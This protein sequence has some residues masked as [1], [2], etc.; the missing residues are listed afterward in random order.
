M[1][2]D[3]LSISLDQLCRFAIVFLRTA[4]MLSVTPIFNSRSI[5]VTTRMAFALILSFFLSGIVDAPSLLGLSAG[6]IVMIGIREMF[7]GA[8]FGFSIHLLFV[9]VQI[10]GQVTGMMMGF[11][12]VNVFD[13]QSQAQTSLIS[14]FK[15]ILALLFFLALNGHHYVIEGL[16]Q[17]F[18]LLPV[19]TAS[20][21]AAAAE[22]LMQRSSEVFVIAMKIAAPGM[23]SLLVL[24][25]SLGLIAKTVPQMNIFIVGFPLKIGLGM[26]SL[27]FSLPFIVILFRGMWIS[28]QIDSSALLRAMGV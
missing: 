15:Y 24:D 8:L 21:T 18:S 19:G 27:G 20:M 13:P 4:I 28:V 7:A 3:W 6:D 16:A 14:Q 1:M 23:V 5:P 9:G 12:I 22:M 11:G 10:A 2:T 25:V 17:S 26:I